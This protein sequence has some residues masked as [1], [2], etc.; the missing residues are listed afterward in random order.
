M[1]SFGAPSVQYN[2]QQ[3]RSWNEMNSWYEPSGPGAMASTANSYGAPTSGQQTSTSYP[4]SF[5]S[6]YGGGQSSTAYPPGTTGSYPSTQ[7]P[8]AYYPSY[9]SMGGGPPAQQSTTGL[10]ADA[11]EE[12]SSRGL[13]ADRLSAFSGVDKSKSKPAKVSRGVPPPVIDLEPSHPPQHHSA[14]VANQR[15][16]GWERLQT[17]IDVGRKADPEGFEGRWE[18][19]KPLGEFIQA[20][21][22]SQMPADFVEAMSVVIPRLLAHLDFSHYEL[23]S[24]LSLYGTVY[25]TDSVQEKMRK[26]PADSC[27][28][29]ITFKTI[30]KVVE[31]FLSAESKG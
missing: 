19:L 5:G 29:G 27:P 9:G 11:Q 1:G 31:E 2:Q 24:Q 3:E 10:S 16:R 22:S 18:T 6:S 20:K 25:V 21:L 8:A 26:L 30:A 14:N 15:F 28:P 12:P 13:F 17:I 23:L 7:P 4:G